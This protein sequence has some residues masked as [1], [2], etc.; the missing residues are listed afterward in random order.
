MLQRSFQRLRNMK[1]NQKLLLSYLIVVLLPI[2]ITVYFLI[3]RV[4]QETYSQTINT[5]KVHYDQL[6]NNIA[7][8]FNSYTLISDSIT[9]A[10]LI[11]FLNTYYPEDTDI[12]TK[13]Y[14]FYDLYTSYRNKYALLSLEGIQI[15]VYSNNPT[16]LYDN[17]FIRFIDND[18]AKEDWYKDTLS[19]VKPY[20]ISQPSLGVNGDYMLSISKLIENNTLS[21]RVN[22]YR[23]E[24]P[25]KPLYNLIEKEGMNKDIYL[26]NSS[27]T[28]VISSNKELIGKTLSEAGLEG[29]ESMNSTVASELKYFSNQERVVFNELLG[30]KYPLEEHRLITVISPSV[31]LG[32]TN[33]IVRYS[34]LVCLTSIAIAIFFIIIFSNTLTKRLK[35]L[36]ATMSKVRDGN[37]NTTIYDADKDEIGELSKSFNKM[38]NRI[39]S[40]INEVYIQDLVVKNLELKRKEAELQALQSQINP[41]F[42]FNTVESIRMNVLK[43]GDVETSEILQSFGKLL[44]KSIEWKSHS[45]SLA[46]EMELVESYVKI[47]KFRYRN[48]FNYEINISSE[49]SKTI[50]PKFIIQPIVENAINHGL[51]MKKKNGVLSIYA[52][53]ISDNL[54]IVIRDNGMGIKA[55]RLRELNDLINDAENS[56]T[57]SSIGLRNVN[58]RIKLLYGNNY[59]LAFSSKLGKGTKVEI[60]LPIG[61]GDVMNV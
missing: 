58:Q 13:Y 34:V 35:S 15:S 30:N 16:I 22:L 42:L 55:E 11:H 7:N 9:E 14:S 3:V 36:V 54:K 19:S 17:N 26:I 23:M 18:I 53:R 51:E 4:T 44:R 10:A 52:C 20:T 43:N 56:N 47:Q 24:I 37:F 61:Q 2:F 46:K 6:R 28:I 57:S 27:G 31:I 25:L 32:K 33:E 8:L 59:G 40:L 39:N 5:N 29:I 49:L 41:H 50:I 48:R 1:I 38:L 45:I 60:L 12:G 21:N